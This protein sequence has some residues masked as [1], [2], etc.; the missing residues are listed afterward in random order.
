[1][2]LAL[3]LAGFPLFAQGYFIMP[4]SGAGKGPEDNA[5]F[6]AYLARQVSA[7]SH[8]INERQDRADFIITPELGS[9]PGQNSSEPLFFLR[10]TLTDN[11]TKKI[12]NEQELIYSTLEN[13][14]N[15]VKVAAGSIFS[16]V[17]P[18]YGEGGSGSDDGDVYEWRDKWLY[19]GGA[20]FWNPRIYY[21][22]GQS[23]QMM[24]FGAGIF[25]ELQFLNFLSVE[26]SVTMTPDWIGIQGMVGDEY[27][28]WILE[29]PVLVKFILKPAA[30]YMIEPYAGIHVNIP[31]YGVSE[32]PM[33]SWR[34]G[35]Q[36]GV[37]AGPGIIFIDPCFSMDL[38][39]S[40][41]TRISD[42]VTIPYSRYVLY[43]GVGYK[44]GFFSR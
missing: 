30:H 29:I 9:W 27:R 11:K 17:I 13:A 40:S 25:G 21:G 36:Y 26:A 31:L 12:I 35:L 1:M 16:G 4:V 14:D 28:D 2:V 39:D 24:N 32:I 5:F 3:L 6:A 23:V 43:L 18:I 8:I 19:L 44:Y 38:G 42:K 7:N 20:F 41:I 15:L 22:Y 34:A 10:I 37:K 33:F